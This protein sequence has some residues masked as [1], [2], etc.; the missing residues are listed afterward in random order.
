M[1]VAE[2][3]KLDNL[4]I[5]ITHKTFNKQTNFIG[6][7]KVIANTQFSNHIRA[8][9]QIQSQGNDSKMKGELQKIDLA[10]FGKLPRRVYES[11]KKHGVN[12]NIILY[13]FFHK[14]SSNEQVVHGYLLTTEEHELL[15]Y[16]LVHLTNKSLSVILECMKYVTNNNIKAAIA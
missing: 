6:K 11:V 10:P 7:G 9:N 3:D 14:N 8:Y 15:D 2:A 16:Y 12:Q 5:K 4:L 13:K 1:K